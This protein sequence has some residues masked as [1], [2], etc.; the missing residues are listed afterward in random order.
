VG[1]GFGA[2]REPDENRCSQRAQTIENSRPAGPRQ[3]ADEV[4]RI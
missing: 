2:P 4:G 1:I 3:P